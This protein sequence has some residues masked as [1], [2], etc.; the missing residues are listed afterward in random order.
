M[1]FFII[2]NGITNGTK[3]IIQH[4]ISYIIKIQGFMT[5]YS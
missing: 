3:N 2:H 4:I 1:G 5:N